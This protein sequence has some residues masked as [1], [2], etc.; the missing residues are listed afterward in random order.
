[1]DKTVV[2]TKT[3][4][5]EIGFNKAQMPVEIKWKSSDAPEGYPTQEAKAMLLTFM[6]APTKDALKIDLWTSDL[7]V[8]E[9][10]VLMYRTLSS[11]ADTYFKAT[12]N[13]ELAEQMRNFAQYF[14]SKT[15][16]LPS[17]K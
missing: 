13:R 15:E 14:A 11:L 17:E 6:D 10:D 8:V 7:Q 5:I 16:L 4:G 2:K 1:M 12:N 3:I 9:M